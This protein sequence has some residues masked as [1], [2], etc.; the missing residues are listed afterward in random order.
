M[1]LEGYADLPPGQIVPRLADQGVY[2]ALRSTFYLMRR[3]TKSVIVSDKEK[4]SC[5]ALG[6]KQ[7]AEQL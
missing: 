7:E 6:V 4:A 3:R 5:K 1:Q 2:L